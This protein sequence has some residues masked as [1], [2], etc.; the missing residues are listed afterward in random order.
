MRELLQLDSKDLEEFITDALIELLKSRLELKSSLTPATGSPKS[1]HVVESVEKTCTRRSPHHST[2][3]NN[4]PELASTYLCSSPADTCDRFIASGQ[5]QLKTH[6]SNPSISRPSLPRT[7]KLDVVSTVPSNQRHFN[8]SKN[9]AHVSRFLA[10]PPA[11]GRERAPQHEFPTSTRRFSS[12]VGT[13]PNSDHHERRSPT[14]ASTTATVDSPRRSF[15]PSRLDNPPNVK[16]KQYFPFPSTQEAHSKYL[17]QPNVCVPD[18]TS[19]HQASRNTET[20][21]RA[22]FKRQSHL[23]NYSG[24]DSKIRAARSSS[25]FCAPP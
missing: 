1:D 18:G 7:T 10:V 22:R 21:K 23:C 16:F 6:S 8:A 13:H 5:T 25:A 17:R 3:F 19:N 15:P 24:V 2:K 4:V 14:F 11:G 9:V 12:V 20:F